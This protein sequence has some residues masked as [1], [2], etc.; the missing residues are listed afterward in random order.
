MDWKQGFEEGLRK[1]I[2]QPEGS[3]PSDKRERMFIYSVVNTLT[4]LEGVSRV[5]MLEDGKKLGSVDE[6]YLGNA[7]MRNPGILVDD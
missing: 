6:I 2:D 5:W 3:I 7:L 4:E 1:Y